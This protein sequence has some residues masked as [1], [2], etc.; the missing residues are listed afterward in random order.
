[1]PPA[2]LRVSDLAWRSLLLKT[3]ALFQQTGQQVYELVFQTRHCDT[4]SHSQ[5]DYR[6]IIQ[7]A[8]LNPRYQ[9]GPR[10]P[11]RETRWKLPK[12]SATKDPAEWEYSRQE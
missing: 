7:C 3:G 8:F 9:S 4:G 12:G 2:I 10:E 6:H 1:M 5:P 11:V